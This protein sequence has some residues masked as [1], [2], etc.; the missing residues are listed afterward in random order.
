MT[1][2]RLLRH[3][4]T[5]ASSARTWSP[6]RPKVAAYRAPG[7]PIAAFGVESAIDE[8]ARKLGMDPIDLR[9]KN[10]APRRRRRP[11]TARPSR[12]SASSRPWRRSRR[13]RTTPSRSAPTRGAASPRASGSTSAANPPPRC[14]SARTAAPRWSTGNPDIGG[15]RASMAMMAAEVLGIPVE[16]RA[17]DR[18]RHRL[19]R[20]LDADRRQPHHLRHRHGRGAGGREGGRRAEAAR[21]QDLGRR[22]RTQVAWEDGAGGLPR[23]RQGRRQAADADG[24]SPASR[25]APAARSRPRCRSTP[26]APGPAS[27]STSATSR[28]TRRPATS[29]SCATPRP[30]TS[31]GRSIRPTSKARCRAARRR[32][33]AG[34]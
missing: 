15:S 2:A 6:T 17:P 24:A 34:R 1:R 13:T 30:R 26:R 32:A 27:A 19:D 25:R 14:T 20:L 11:P 21:R 3:R 18:R 9:P 23:R 22:R 7:A 10:G 28:S 29:R 12:T 31:A 4:R 8:L 33:S 16:Q 5:S